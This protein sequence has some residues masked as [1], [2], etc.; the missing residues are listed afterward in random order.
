VKKYY[1]LSAILATFSW[2]MAQELTTYSVYDT[3]HNG[4]L[5][6]A[7][8]TGVIEQVK[9]SV[10]SNETQQY[11][12][13]EDLKSLLQVINTKLEKLESIENRLTSIEAKVGIESPND[14]PASDPYNGHAYVDLG[15]T[16][17]N[18]KKLL[19]A[20]CNVG[21]TNPEDYGQYFAWGATTGCD[22]TI[23]TCN[24]HSFDWS[25]APF[26]GGNSDYSSSAW[27]SAKSTAVDANNI[28]LPA[29]DA[30]TANW[31]GSWRMPTFDEQT[32]LCT[33]CYWEWVA[34]YNG[35]SVKGYVVY[36]AKADADRG[37]YSYDNPTLST[38]YSVASDAHIFMPAAGY[39][40]DSSLGNDGSSGYYWSSSLSESYPGSA[41]YLFF[42][43]GDVGASGDNRY[44]GFAVRAVC[45]SSE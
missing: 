21:A 41:W 33:G 38:T 39:R 44:S 7:D 19:W 23:G 27:S 18:G 26:N 11:V 24:D 35:K 6:A 30:A 40:I 13:A 10:A 12:T 4:E 17:A 43:S 5:T 9:N 22:N 45:P 37:K 8:A 20:T 15:I 1:L 31:G 2:T 34:T 16:D 29:N 28:L 36:K 42:Y 14:D 25:H 32:K 3:N